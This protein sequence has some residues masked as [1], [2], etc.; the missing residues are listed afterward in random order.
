MDGAWQDSA[1][2][3]AVRL[4]RKGKAW[5]GRVWSGGA[6]QVRQGT[7]EH[8]E[9]VLGRRGNARLVGLR[10]RRRGGHFDA[11]NGKVKS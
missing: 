7:A 10:Q 8:G 1:G 6:M 9:A 11:P 4:G 2:Y 3:G 5:Y